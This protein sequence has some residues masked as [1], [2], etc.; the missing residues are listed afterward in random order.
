M[1]RFSSKCVFHQ[2]AAVGYGHDIV[3]SVETV[4]VSIA[5]DDKLIWMLSQGVDD[6]LEISLSVTS[7]SESR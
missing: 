3:D 1:A 4:D 5:A 6:V 7:V 2:I